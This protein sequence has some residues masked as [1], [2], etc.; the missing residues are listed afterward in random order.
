MAM[1]KHVFCFGILLTCSTATFAGARID[2]RPQ[3]LTITPGDIPSVTVTPGQTLNLQAF[4][5]DTGNP[6][7]AIAFRGVFLD[8][9]DT[10][11]SIVEANV[12][13]GTDGNLLTEGDNPILF[14][15]I[16]PFTVGKDFDPMPRVDWIYPLP[17][18]SP[19]FQIT[20]PD[21]GEIQLGS[22]LVDVPSQLPAIIDVMNADVPN[23]F[24]G[25][26]VDF[27]FGG[28]NDPVTTWRAHTGELTG[29]QL[30]LIPEPATLLL[31]VV[32]TFVALNTRPKKGA[33]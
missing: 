11:S 18:P 15:W 3:G 17:T 32:G 30:L 31:F 26:R 25:A 7:G 23:V 33:N 22:I 16:N 10:S 6:Q 27:G 8:F 19:L 28:P 9:T 24:Y 14:E 4:I 12:W 1:K 2:L 21:N 29:G 13:G 20:L 5:V